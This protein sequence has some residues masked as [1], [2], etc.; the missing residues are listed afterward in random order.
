MAHFRKR[1]NVEQAMEYLEELELDDAVAGADVFLEPPTN[2]NLSDEDS[3]DED[4][5]GDMDNFNRN[6][7]L[8]NVELRVQAAEGFQDDLFEEDDA[9]PMDVDPPGPL[10]YPPL[11]T[12]LKW[13]KRGSFADL[14]AGDIDNAHLGQLTYHTPVQMF[15][16]FFSDD[17]RHSLEKVVV[18]R[19]FILS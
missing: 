5:G 16:L 13:S 11:P 18:W 14:N 2:G 15:E 9:T 19:L 1:M 12:Q 6:Q 17:N 8:A 3:A 4:I 7:L 10:T